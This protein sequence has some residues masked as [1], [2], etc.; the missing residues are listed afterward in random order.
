MASSL[1][2]C[3][4]ARR[5]ALLTT[6]ISASIVAV[7]SPRIFSWSSPS[8]MAGA[9]RRKER[10]DQYI[11]ATAAHLN[12]TSNPTR[13]R[14][15]CEETDTQRPSRKMVTACKSFGVESM[16]LL[17]MLREEFPDEGF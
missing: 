9:R 13:Y 3:W 14:V 11:V 17:E 8:A 2:I 4:L 12:A 6:V 5:S 15:V 7:H 16:S 1:L 10:A